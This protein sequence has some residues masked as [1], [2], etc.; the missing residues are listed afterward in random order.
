MVVH[1]IDTSGFRKSAVEVQDKIA[2]DI[3]ATDLL[4]II[5]KTE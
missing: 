5:R 3:G 2:K 4:D 1:P